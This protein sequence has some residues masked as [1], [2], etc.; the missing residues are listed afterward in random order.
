MSTEE[1]KLK[2]VKNCIKNEP[3]KLELFRISN[4]PSIDTQDANAILVNAH[5]VHIRNINATQCQIGLNVVHFYA[6]NNKIDNVI[7]KALPDVTSKLISLSLSHNKLTNLST[8][9]TIRNLKFLDLANNSIKTFDIETLSKLK[10]LVTL[11]LGYNEIK[12]VDFGL[13][14]SLQKLQRLILSHNVISNFRLDRVLPA[15]KAIYLENNALL[16]IDLSLKS[17]A[18]K[19]KDLV[20][21]G[22]NWSCDI[23]NKIVR[24]LV[25][26]GIYLYGRIDF[27]DEL[28]WDENEEMLPVNDVVT[29]IGCYSGGPIWAN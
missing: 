4:N 27:R 23:L 21:K 6:D 1:N 22:N 13:I 28:R 14:D 15:L 25:Q 29:M 11:D 8:L 17:K 19:L 10:E 24:T 9:G 7:V 16:E 18:P 5:E 3:S 20:L 2:V 26:D 12:S